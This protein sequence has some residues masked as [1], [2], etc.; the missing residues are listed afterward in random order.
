MLGILITRAHKSQQ[1][2]RDRVGVRLSDSRLRFACHECSSSQ[3]AS[4]LPPNYG[5][6]PLVI[7]AVATRSDT[8]SA[9]LSQQMN[10][11]E[12]SADCV[13]S[14]IHPQEST[15]KVPPSTASGSQQVSIDD[16]PQHLFFTR[17]STVVDSR[18][19]KRENT[20]LAPNR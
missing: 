7:P 3:F 1:V 4:R 19:R 18:R 20:A 14:R 5:Q 11:G 15:R 16:N 6:I 2:I 8:D 13:F 10:I 17:F 12:I 9:S